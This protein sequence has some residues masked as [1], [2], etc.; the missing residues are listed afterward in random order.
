M[1]KASLSTGTGAARRRAHRGLCV[2]ATSITLLTTGAATAADPFVP[3]EMQISPN[4]G[5]ID[6]EV[7]QGRAK[8][9]WTDPVGGLWLGDIDRQTGAFEPNDGRG[10]QIADGSVHGMHEFLWNGP[11]WISTAS[12]DQIMYSYYLPNRRPTASAT[13]MAIAAQDRSGNWVSRPLAP[14]NA[15][16]MF[17]VSSHTEGDPNAQIMYFD[18]DYNHYWRNVADAGSEVLLSFLPQED[19]A[20]R[21][22][23][24]VRAMLYTQ[25]V[26]GVPQVFRYMLDTAAS[27]QLTFDA[28]AKDT[29][30]TVPWMWPA[31]EFDN[32]LVFSTVVDGNELRIYRQ[33]PPSNAWTQIYSAKLP[34][35]TAVGSPEWFVYNGKSYLF[36]AAFVGANDFPTEIWVSNIDQAHPLLRRINDD[37]EF[38]ARNDPEVFVTGDRG[39]LIYYNRYDP[40]LK[41]GHPMCG[42]CSEGV[43]A[44]DPGLLGM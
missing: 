42:A 36:M 41:P 8:I 22:A 7:S 19:K 23:T 17:D 43:Y 12:G 26:A 3:N 15:P 4:R 21:F 28:G 20:W 30:R 11:E 14:L 18:P 16:R 33:L 32:A 38:K 6:F 25:P 1:E 35:G 39:P 31:P 13:R 44:A 29:G 40:T 10:Q 2:L 37:T 27:E 9:V 5:L 24:G 34:D